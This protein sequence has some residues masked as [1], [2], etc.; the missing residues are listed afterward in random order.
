[1]R[2]VDAMT[3]RTLREGD[4]IPGG[5][6]RG[7]RFAGVVEEHIFSAKALFVNLARQREEVVPL[8]VRYM[9]PSFRFQKIGFVPT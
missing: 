1:M 9:H 6:G 2:V 8:V 5:D 4:V 7:Y 3:G